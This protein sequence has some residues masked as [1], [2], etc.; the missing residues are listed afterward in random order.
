MRFQVWPW[1]DMDFDDSDKPD[2]TTSDEA[3]MEQNE[4]SN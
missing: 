4:A 2:L 3:F 1:L